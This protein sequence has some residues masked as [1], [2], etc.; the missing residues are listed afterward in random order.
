M[1]A[2]KYIQET[3]QEEYKKGSEYYKKRVHDWRNGPAIVRLERPTNISR[4]RRLG[5]KAKQGYVIVMVR[6]P[7]GRRGRRKPMGGRKPRHNYIF[8]QPQQ[9]HQNLAEKRANI[10]YKNLEVVNSYWVGEDGNYKFF[11]IIMAAP[12]L[13]SVSLQSVQRKGR[14]FRGLTSAGKK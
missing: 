5:Y 6:M 11:E 14:A 12:K 3:F 4:A 9:S 2:N 13:N 10:R 1:G 8:V 7:K